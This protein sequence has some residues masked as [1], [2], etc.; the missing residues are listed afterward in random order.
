MNQVVA[1]V[2]KVDAFCGRIRCEEDPDLAVLAAKTVDQGL[3]ILII[4]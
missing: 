4:E 2:V 3:L 1:V